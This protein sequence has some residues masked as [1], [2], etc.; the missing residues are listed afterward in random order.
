MLPPPPYQETKEMKTNYIK[1][2]IKVKAI[3]S[4]YVMAAVSVGGN[5]GIE[6]GG[7]GG[8]TPPTSGS[9]KGYDADDNEWPSARSAWGE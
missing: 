3:S 9:S 5:T 4:L 2:S 7:E 6:I 1:P 8:E